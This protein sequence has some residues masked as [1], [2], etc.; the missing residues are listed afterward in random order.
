MQGEITVYMPLETSQIIPPEVIAGIDCQTIAAG[1]VECRS[2]GITDSQRNPNYHPFEAVSRNIG[3]DRITSRPSCGG[4]GGYTA[5][6]D[7]D[8]RHLRETNFEE[9]IA[10]LD[11][12]PAWGG[13]GLYQG[14]AGKSINLEPK[15]VR[16]SC[17]ILRNELWRLLRFDEKSKRCLCNYVAETIRTA[18]FRFGFL[19][20]DNRRITEILDRDKRHLP[21]GSANKNVQTSLMPRRIRPGVSALSSRTGR[22][23]ESGRRRRSP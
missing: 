1:I 23:E 4:I 7:S 2:K 8:I 9:M 21:A 17:F 22:I 19:D 14:A 20:A 3:I 18:G 5:M 11:G 12:N 6:Q 10:F 16:L 15:H 13:V